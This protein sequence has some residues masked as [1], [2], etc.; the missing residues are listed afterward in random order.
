MK[1]TNAVK[2]AYV[3]KCAVAPHSL[4]SLRFPAVDASIAD[5]P[6]SAVNWIR[7]RPRIDGRTAGLRRALVV[8]VTS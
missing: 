3:K 1:C 6:D 4:L 7:R 8:A 5:V 2:D